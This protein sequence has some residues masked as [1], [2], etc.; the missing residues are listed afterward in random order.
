[1]TKPVEVIV[2]AET[3][4]VREGVQR[5]LESLGVPDWTS[6]AGDEH[7]EL[8]EIAGRLCY[9][10]FSP[11]LNANLT[12]VRNNNAA[13]IRNILDQ[14]HGSIFEHSTVTFALLNVSRI[15]THELVR[16]RQGI[17][18]S[19]ESQRF[20]RLEEFNVYIPEL[21]SVLTQ[22]AQYT[23]PDQSREDNQIWA[24]QAQA[25]FFD[26]A[27]KLSEESRV[28]LKE[29]SEALGLNSQKLPFKLK[30]DLTSA[31]RRFIPGGVTTD[32]IVTAN[33]RTWRYLIEV[34]TAFG[35]EEEIRS[36]FGM[37]F[38]HLW[39]RYPTIYQDRIH[40]LKVGNHICATYFH[41][42]KI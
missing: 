42:S 9:K 33:H 18:F 22:V 30:K 3:R 20:V 31:L 38:D 41:N 23:Y 19:Q 12:K 7:S 11:E 28:K 6:N 26:T 25:H 2:L 36:V 4:L 32:I 35:A 34:R 16:H 40:E 13:Y 29:L 5:L 10:S 37:I 27:Q 39:D 17:A 14:R 8:S 15:L 21:T 1:M 24:Q